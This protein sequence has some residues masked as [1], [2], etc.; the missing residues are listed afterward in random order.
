MLS[1]AL[2]WN[3]LEEQLLNARTSSDTSRKKIFDFAMEQRALLRTS[4]QQCSDAGEMVAFSS[5]DP[6]RRPLPG[7]MYQLATSPLDS[8]IPHRAAPQYTLSEMSSHHSW[9]STKRGRES[10]LHKETV[11][12][13][14]AVLD[15]STHLH[16][17]PLPRNPSLARFV[18]AA[19]D[20][21]IP[22]ENIASME[23]TWPGSHTPCACCFLL[24]NP[25]FVVLSRL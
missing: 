13:L 12:T 19:D 10:A 21:Y 8:D 9:L 16:N 1:G 7:S 15:L 5:M 22:R 25:V 20:L 17:Y 3:V 14:G 24:Y 2:S 6:S 11:A 18:A 23:D 4:T